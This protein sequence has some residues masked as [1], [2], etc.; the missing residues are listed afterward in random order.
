[1][2]INQKVIDK[3]REYAKKFYTKVYF[4]HSWNSHVA[5]VVDKAKYIARKEKMDVKIAEMG[6][7]LHDIGRIKT[8]PEEDH[9]IPSAKIAEPFLKSL[10]L[11]KEIIDKIL[12]TIKFHSGTEISKAKTNEAKAVYDAD[13]LNHL[14][15]VGIIRTACWKAYKNPKTDLDELFFKTVGVGKRRIKRMQTK[16]GKMLAKKY[17][18][19]TKEFI[20]GYKEMKK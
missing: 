20:K 9:A 11:D 3:T 6:A 7:L 15:P 8:K 4:T 10:K 13:K 17:L 2:Q 5:F 19:Y 1:M 14:G 12:D 18:D 16:T